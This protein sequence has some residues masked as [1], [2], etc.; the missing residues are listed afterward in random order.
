MIAQLLPRQNTFRSYSTCSMCSSILNFT[1]PYPVGFCPINM[2]ALCLLLPAS[3]HA[4][5]YASR[6]YAGLSR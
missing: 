4:E 1:L 3:T 6:I 5:N 2:L